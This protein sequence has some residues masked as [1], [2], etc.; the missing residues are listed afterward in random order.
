MKK[1]VAEATELVDG[2]KLE[3]ANQTEVDVVLCPPFTALERVSVAIRETRIRRNMVIDDV[4]AMSGLSRAY[5]S[6]VE[7]GKASP[8]R[9]GGNLFDRLWKSLGGGGGGTTEKNDEHNRRGDP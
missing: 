4:A 3:L 1:T 8:A 6:Q 2:L 9:R 7:T 5:I